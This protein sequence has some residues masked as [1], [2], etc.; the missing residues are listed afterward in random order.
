MG[1]YLKEIINDD[2]TIWSKSSL[3]VTYNDHYKNNAIT[4]NYGPYTRVFYAFSCMKKSAKAAEAPC[5]VIAK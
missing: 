2:W 3:K 5:S 4:T 1:N